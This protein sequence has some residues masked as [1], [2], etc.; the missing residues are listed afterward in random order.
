M[1]SFTLILI[2]RCLHIPLEYF[3]L[4]RLRL[5]LKDALVGNFEPREPQREKKADLDHHRRSNPS[6]CWQYLR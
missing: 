2:S 4:H 6:L 1:E 5:N 3:E